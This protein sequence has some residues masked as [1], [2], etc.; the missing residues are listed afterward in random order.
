M[1]NLI[2]IIICGG[3]GTRL[4][5]LSNKDNPKQFLKIFNNKSLFDLT[6]ERCNL[7][8]KENLI[9]I[10]SIENKKDI[11]LSLKKYNRKASIVFEEI[12]RNTTAAIFLV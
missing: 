1:K 5:P 6:I 8:S 12:G 11:D 2:P 4:W 9:I 7:I 10:A 3:S